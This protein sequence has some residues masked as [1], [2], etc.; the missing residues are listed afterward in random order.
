MK[1]A[2]S[3]IL[4]AGGEAPAIGK[5]AALIGDAAFVAAAD[6]GLIAATRAGFRPDLIIGDMDSLG[7]ES[8][9]AECPQ[10]EVIRLKSDKDLSD[11]EAALRLLKGR[12]FFDITLIGAGGGRLDHLIAVLRIFET[13]F[14]PSL[15][16]TQMNAACLLQAEKRDVLAAFGLEKGDAVSVFALGKPPHIIEGCGLKWSLDI[17]W[18]GE[19]KNRPIRESLS[20]WVQAERV[21]LKALRGDF[22]CVFPLK[23][24]LA[25]ERLPR[26]PQ[27]RL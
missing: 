13:D 11:T 14:A 26:S 2:R 3:A 19:D 1:I 6:S 9:I 4:F 22:L 23:E 25:L 17:P 8:L 21:T 16:L 12:G 20:N 27:E 10:A 5:A 24:S 7:D 15:W 18:D